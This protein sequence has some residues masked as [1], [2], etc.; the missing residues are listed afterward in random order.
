MSSD[1]NEKTERAKTSEQVEP[2]GK[3]QWTKDSSY[4]LVGPDQESFLHFQDKRTL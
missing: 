2:G 3:I 1:E 4:T